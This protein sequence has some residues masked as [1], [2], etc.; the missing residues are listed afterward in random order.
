MGTVNHW[1]FRRALLVDK[2]EESFERINEATKLLGAAG[3][4]QTDE[5]L[6]FGAHRREMPQCLQA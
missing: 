4:R 1:H 2:V 6:N 3:G 5:I